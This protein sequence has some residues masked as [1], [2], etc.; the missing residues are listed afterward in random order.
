MQLWKLEYE[1]DGVSACKYERNLYRGCMQSCMLHGSETW[2][3]K[4]D[5]MTLQWAEMR[6]IR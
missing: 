5:E 4:K 2:V 6:M 1:V 3:V